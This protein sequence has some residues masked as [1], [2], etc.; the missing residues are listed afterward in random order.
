[1]KMKCVGTTCWP[2][3]AVD[4]PGFQDTSAREDRPSCDL[5]AKEGVS[6]NLYTT[7]FAKAYVF[8]FLKKQTNINGDSS[9]YFPQPTL[10]TSGINSCGR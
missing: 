1:M 10:E 9:I 4:L 2:L 5:W 8:A 3:H 6:I 7:Y